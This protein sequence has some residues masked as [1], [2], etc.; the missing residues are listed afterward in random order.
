MSDSQRQRKTRHT[1]HETSGAAP[2]ETKPI[3]GQCAGRCSKYH[4]LLLGGRSL[5]LTSL[6]RQQMQCMLHRIW[7]TLC[8]LAYWTGLNSIE[9]Y[10]TVFNTT[11]R[12]IRK[13][14]RQKLRRMQRKWKNDQKFNNLQQRPF[15][16]ARNC[17]QWRRRD[18]TLLW[19]LRDPH[20]IATPP[21]RWQPSWQRVAHS[22][23]GGFCSLTCPTPCPCAYW[24]A[25]KSVEW[26]WRVFNT[27]V[28]TRSYERALWK[29]QH[30]IFWDFRNSGAVILTTVWKTP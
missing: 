9:E 13:P 20:P 18:E 6:L 25:L 14:I 1:R 27:A 29:A 30:D 21:H 26:F 5:H 2:A 7:P 15:R 10:R 16:H 12:L 11:G 4:T 23:R 3:L 19:R 24:R 28:P 17:F 8:P 22:K